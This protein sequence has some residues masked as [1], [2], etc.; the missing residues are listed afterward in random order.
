MAVGT[1]AIQSQTTP[2]EP[3]IVAPEEFAA[4]TRKNEHWVETK[5]APSGSIFGMNWLRQLPQVGIISRTR[6]FFRGTMVV[7]SGG[8]TASNQWPYNLL[9]KFNLSA[10]GQNN[11]WSCDGIDLHVH[12]SARFPAYREN[13]D[14]FPGAVGGGAIVAG[15][16]DV[17]L[18]WETPIAADDTSLVGALYAQSGATNL[19][20]ERQV[21]AL[22]DLFSANAD[23]VT[24]SGEFVTDVTRFSVPRSAAEGHPLVIP[25]LTRLHAFNAVDLQFSATGDVRLPL[26]RSA[27]QLHRLYVAVEKSATARLSALPDTAAA[28][29]IDALRVEYGAGE[30]PY[31]YNPAA[32]LLGRNNDHY[33]DI[34]PYD[35]LCLDMVRENA[36]RDVILLQGVTELNVIPTINSAASITAGKARLVQETLF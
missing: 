21:A 31:D 17:F 19:S 16:Y 34:L 10:N 8:T 3:F 30:R 2:A 12:R 13:V 1:G 6:T 32:T 9:K 33:G 23:K 35:R 28:S 20:L 14:V 25:D 11:L 15:T 26:I 5:D 7:A 18:S 4:M 27:G 36:P 22:A 24:L 29:R